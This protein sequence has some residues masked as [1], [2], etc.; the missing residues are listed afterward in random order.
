M[1]LID[2]FSI[3]NNQVTRG[4]SKIVF[5]LQVLVQAPIIEIFLHMFDDDVDIFVMGVL[6]IWRLM[7]VHV[8]I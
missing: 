1:I 8:I 2:S 4:I 5:H 6:G 7:G 3:S